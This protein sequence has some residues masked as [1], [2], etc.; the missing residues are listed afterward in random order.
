MEFGVTN[1]I[2]DDV[3]FTL[4]TTFLNDWSQMLFYQCLHY[5]FCVVLNEQFL[6]LNKL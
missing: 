2:L 4:K 5:V 3:E 6:L 1:E